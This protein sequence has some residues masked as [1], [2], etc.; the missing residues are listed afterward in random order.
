M[1]CCDYSPILTAFVWQADVKLV[2]HLM[3]WFIANQLRPDWRRPKCAC[4]RPKFDRTTPAGIFPPTCTPP[5]RSSNR[6]YPSAFRSCRSHGSRIHIRMKTVAPPL[7]MIFTFD[8]KCTCIYTSTSSSPQSGQA[9]HRVDMIW[10]QTTRRGDGV[11][12]V[13]VKIGAIPCVDIS[14]GRA[15]QTHNRPESH[16]RNVTLSATDKC[17]FDL[18]TDVVGTNTHRD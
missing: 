12:G 1:L 18:L 10:T 3:G 17:D 14:G 5:L 4:H 2:K 8:S 11:C 15:S 13:S 9:T 7:D 16:N 6:R